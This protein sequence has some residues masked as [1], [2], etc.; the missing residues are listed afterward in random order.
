MQL[1]RSSDDIL[2]PGIAVM[3]IVL[4]CGASAMM[5][6]PT[7]RNCT[8]TSVNVQRD[9]VTSNKELKNIS[10]DDKKTLCPAYRRRADILREATGPN[11]LCLEA[12]SSLPLNLQAELTVYT[13]LAQE[14]CGTP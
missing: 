5:F 2:W 14:A 8:T 12:R 9:L 13:R 4:A 3:V 11:G 7:G 10:L 6:L 1:L